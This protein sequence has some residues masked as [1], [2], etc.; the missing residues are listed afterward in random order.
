[1]NQ[2]LNQFAQTSNLGML[3]LQSR[4]GT[5]I[6]VAVS[7]NIGTGTLV[8]GQPV[9]LDTAQTG[10]V[11]QVLPCTSDADPVFG[12]VNFSL[13]DQSFASG[14]RLEIALV[15]CVMF[16]NSNA[17]IT[18]GAPVEIDITAAGNVGPSAGINPIVGYA[19][20]SASAT[21][22]LLRVFITT[23]PAQ[24]AGVVQ[25]GVVS[26]TLAEI[27][28]GQVLIP[29]V[30]GK[31]ITVTNY[32]FRVTGTFTTATAVVL[33]ST[34]A[35]PVVV[36]T[37]AIADVTDGAVL[38]P[39]STGATLGAGFAAPLGVGDGLEIAKT[40]TAAAGGTSIEVTVSYV[41]E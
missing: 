20:D 3:D 30:A 15:G 35:N 8:A 34:N 36:T 14:A 22:Q 25:A 37:E 33:Q 4:G 17:A 12:F 10:G 1:M 24:K 27:N 7:S 16:M 11:P 31:T 28:A 38:G 18:R 9:K 5:V 26:A 32:T 6:S 21:G 13:K 19:L 40:G 2:T 23:L 41:Q 39:Y 29:A